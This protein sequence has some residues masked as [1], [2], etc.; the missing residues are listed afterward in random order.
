MWMPRRRLMWIVF[1]SASLGMISGIA[2][3]FT[4]MRPMPSP[5]PVPSTDVPR[6]VS[7]AIEAG[8]GGL[9]PG[10]TFSRPVARPVRIG[11]PRSSGRTRAGASCK[12]GTWP[13]FDSHCLWA[14]PAK[15]RHPRPTPVRQEPWVVALATTTAS[16]RS[17]VALVPA[18]MVKPI[19]TSSDR[20]RAPALKPSLAN[21]KAA[22]PTPLSP[23]VYGAYA[24]VPRAIR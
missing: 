11:E 15:Q 22:V 9:A 7:A 2:G 10:E 20:A 14:A 23:D 8:F 5:T 4:A 6:S 17:A 13:Y 12:Q 21:R 3:A 1:I 24:A 16:L 19:I 18:S